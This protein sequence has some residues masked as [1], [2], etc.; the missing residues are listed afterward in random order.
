MSVN[1]KD[2]H[3]LSHSA[4]DWPELEV[5]L[6]Q[7]VWFVLRRVDLEPQQPRSANLIHTFGNYLS[8]DSCF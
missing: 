4:S 8:Y 2:M 1:N 7:V 6:G 5:V 3:D